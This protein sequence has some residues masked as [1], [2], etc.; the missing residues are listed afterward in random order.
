MSPT[1]TLIAALCFLCLT[2]PLAAQLPK[3]GGRLTRNNDADRPTDPSQESRMMIPEEVGGKTYTE[4][5]GDLIH[6]DPAAKGRAILALLAFGSKS[7][8]AVPALLPIV[9]NGKE[10]PG[11]KAKGLLALKVMGT[12]IDGADREKVIKALGFVIGNDPNSI[13]RYE[14]VQTLLVL[15]ADKKAAKA[16][17]AIT[18]DLVMRLDDPA[19]ETRQAC[20]TA[21]I[22][23]VD[24]KEG[25]NPRVTD[26]LIRHTKPYYE[27]SNEVRMQAIIALGAMGR[28]Q[29]PKKLDVVKGAL[30]DHDRSSDTAIK[31]WTHVSLM[32]LED[33]VNEKDVNLIV[34]SLNDANREVRK[35]AVTA[36]GVVAALGDRAEKNSKYVKEICTRLETEKETMVQEA[37]CRTLARMGDKDPQVLR[38]LIRLTEQDKQKTNAVVLAACAALAH[39]HVASPKVMKALN[40][41]R[42]HKALSDPELKRVEDYIKILESPLPAAPKRG[43]KP[44]K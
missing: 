10:D 2:L 35:Q 22:A 8:E 21:L 43:G 34:H 3:G 40:E 25:P 36:L 42:K 13:V 4:W 16:A 18:N 24:S 17:S 31:I 28:P 26:A 7:L 38:A 30:H 9:K 11:V 29:E 32:A 41:V 33:K 37:A 39:L 27:P 5:K 1:K 15:M 14:A 23:C 12:S 20:I 19:Y 44:D 6:R